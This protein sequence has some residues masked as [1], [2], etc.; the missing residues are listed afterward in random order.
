VFE[1]AILVIAGLVEEV[2]IAGGG[3]LVDN[4]EYADGGDVDAEADVDAEEVDIMLLSLSLMTVGYM[5]TGLV[6]FIAG[7]FGSTAPSFDDE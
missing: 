3:E 7:R 4:E 5:L 2:S 1:A 6:A